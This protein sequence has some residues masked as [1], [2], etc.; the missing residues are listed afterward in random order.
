MKHFTRLLVIVIA[1]CVFSPPKANAQS[2][3]QTALSN[4]VI[5][6]HYTQEQLE[7]LAL[8]DT[9]ELNSIVYYFTASFIVEPIQCF[10]C[11]PFDSLM[12]DV[13][14]YEHLRARDS[15][16]TREFG[17]YGFTLTLVPINQLPY[18]YEIHQVPVLDPGEIPQT[19]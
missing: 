12:F 4:P 19:H 16:Y 1:L 5:M 14:T 15:V 17:K 3:L 8:Q 7:E 11:L 13:S 9:T 2:A 6:L 10:D 18:T